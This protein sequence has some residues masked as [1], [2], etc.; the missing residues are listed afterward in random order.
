MFLLLL[1]TKEAS[2]SQ[3]MGVS[4]DYFLK[5][6]GYA[7][8]KVKMGSLVLLLLLISRMPENQK[9]SWTAAIS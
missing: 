6:M 3:G 9:E 5:R 8:S 7:C 4:S 1:F 2:C